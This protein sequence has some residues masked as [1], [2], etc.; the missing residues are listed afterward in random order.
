MNNVKNLKENTHG[1]SIKFSK[2]Y[3]TKC[4]LKTHPHDFQHLQ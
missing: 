2:Q 4:D 1:W 3:L